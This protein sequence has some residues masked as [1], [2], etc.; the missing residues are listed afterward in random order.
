MVA[1]SLCKN[2]KKSGG[3]DAGFGDTLDFWPVK[4]ETLEIV[5]FSTTFAQS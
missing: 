3:G 1:A 5:S 4:S 2:G